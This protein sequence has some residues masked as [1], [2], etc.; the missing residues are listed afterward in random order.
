M[1]KICPFCNRNNIVK[2]VYGMPNKKGIEDYNKG[3]IHLGGC[4]ISPMDNKYHCMDCNNDFNKKYY[5]E[6]SLI[7][8]IVIDI[9]N[10][11]SSYE[12]LTMKKN[13]NNS[14]LKS[15]IEDKKI[16]IDFL[17]EITH[18]INA[19]CLLDLK[20][21][22]NN[23]NVKILDGEV[24]QISMFSENNIV[25]SVYCNNSIPKVVKLLI[26]YLKNKFF[27]D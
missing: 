6:L 24:I 17:K 13:K 2:I 10:F 20:D 11:G 8:K 7:D 15:N 5:V 22:Y 3:L 12:R 27:E 23:Q 16:K 25:K 26:R 18:L 19:Y 21:T 4:C 9:M 14:Y 1:K